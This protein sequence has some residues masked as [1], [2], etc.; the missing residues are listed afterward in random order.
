MAKRDQERREEID[1]LGNRPD[2]RDE[3]G[4]FLD[5]YEKTRSPENFEA[6]FNR[7]VVAT[8]CLLAPL[9][10]FYALDIQPLKLYGGSPALGQLAGPDVPATMC[11]AMK[12]LLLE[13]EAVPS[14]KSIPWVIPTTCFWVRKFFDQAKFLGR[15][16]GSVHYLETPKVK[17]SALAQNNWLLQI[18][19]LADHLKTI[20][21]VSLTRNRLLAAIKVF[22]RARRGIFELLELKKVG[23][24]P[25]SWFLAITGSFFLDRTENWILAVEKAKNVFAKGRGDIKGAAFPGIFLSGS[26]IHFPNFKLVHLLEEVGLTVLVDDLC[27]GERVIPRHLAIGDPSLAG[28]LKALAETY[29]LGCQCPIFAGSERRLNSIY[30]AYR[31]VNLKGVIFHVLKGCHCFDQDSCLLVNRLGK[32][33]FKLLRLETDYSPADAPNL[34][35]RLEAFRSLISSPMAPAFSPEVGSTDQPPRIGQRL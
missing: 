28:I 31:S 35:T 22:Q 29:F 13:L 16:S 20:S 32:A 23:K 25:L 21:K 17:T 33:G 8:F 24:V 12:S 9:E 15:A 10:L 5:L 3:F 11:P 30:Q 19:A 7:P 4:Y 26:P 6:R 18:Y 14:L 27:S 1:S 34:L 2:F